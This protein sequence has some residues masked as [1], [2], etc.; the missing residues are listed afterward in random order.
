MLTPPGQLFEFPTYSKGGPLGPIHWW[1]PDSH[2][3]SPAYVKLSEAPLRISA[4]HS[5]REKY[6]QGKSCPKCWGPTPVFYCHPVPCLAILQIHY[7][8]RSTLLQQG[9]FVWITL[10]NVTGYGS[11][12]QHLFHDNQETAA[13]KSI[14]KKR[15]KKRRNNFENIRYETNDVIIK[16]SII[17]GGGC[18]KNLSLFIFKSPERRSTFSSNREYS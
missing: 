5:G 16:F 13:I 2:P 8:F 12:Q 6:L 14:F 18:S 1:I 15:R 3:W 4:T 10:S 7:N 11:P 17:N 9:K